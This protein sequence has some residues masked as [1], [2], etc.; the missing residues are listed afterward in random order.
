M[1]RAQAK[2]KLAVDGQRGDAHFEV[3]DFVYLKLRPYRLRFL[4]K[5][6]NEKLSTRY[7]GP[8]KVVQRV[9]LVAYKIELSSSTS[10][11]PV[12]HVLQL[13][14]ALGATF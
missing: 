13:K 1:T 7:F 8:Y 5:K 6:L 11:H 4:A 3:E 12:F 2:M 14:R 10:I 9:G